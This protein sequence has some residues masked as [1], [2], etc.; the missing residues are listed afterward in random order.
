MLLALGRD[1][2][3]LNRTGQASLEAEVLS[4]GNSAMLT[5]QQSMSQLLMRA[6]GPVPGLPEALETVLMRVG[7]PGRRSVLGQFRPERWDTTSAL[8]L[9]EILIADHHL[10]ADVEEVANTLLHELAHLLA[11]VR[12]LRDNSNR[13]RYHNAGFKLCAQD[14]GLVVRYQKPFGYQ[15]ECLSPVLRMQLAD[16]LLDLR[17]ALV[18]KLSI[19]TKTPIRIEVGDDLGDVTS[20][21]KRKSV[22]AVCGC[23]DARGR[24]QPIRV[25]VGRWRPRSIFCVICGAWF[26]DP[27]E[28]LTNVGQRD[29]TPAIDI[30]ARMVSGEFPMEK[31][32]RLW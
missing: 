32:V 18:L 30:A 11:K 12:G 15:T 6:A 20:P 13:G 8:R 31:E 19:P 26:R 4:I 16:E 25:A 1:M 14:I 9:H 10:D 2:R 3:S 27:E 5:L 24:P 28:S 21:A 17:R 22:F 7:D 29:V 23:I